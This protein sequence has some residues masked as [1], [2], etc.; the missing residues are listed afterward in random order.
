MQDGVVDGGVGEAGSGSAADGEGG[1]AA[2]ALVSGGGGG[3]GSAIC[4]ALAEDGRAVAV[5]DLD[6]EAAE[7]VCERLRRDGAEAIA[8]QLDVR[9][10]ASVAT[11]ARNAEAELGAIDVLVSNAGWDEMKPF[12]ETDE[13]F[14]AKVIEINFVGALRLTRAL[15]PAMCERGHGRLVCVASDAALVGSSGEAV[16]AGA[17]GALISFTKS[18]ARE[19][20]RSGVTANV[21][22]P[23][24]TDTP[25]LSALAGEGEDAAKLVEALRRAVPMRRLGSR[26]D[27][28]SAVAFLA[29]DS[30]GYITGQTLSVS[31]GLTMA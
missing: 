3:I 28:A 12:L 25:L 31:G 5:A 7:E 30:A 2:A 24:P 10:G 21:V 18:I 19:A 8:L 17:K 29:S 23:G 20:A 4:E 1:G 26:R 11:A 14:W 6:V 27:V 9:D 13:D 22:C 15:L 16:Y